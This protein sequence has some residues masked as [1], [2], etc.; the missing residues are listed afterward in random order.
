MGELSYKLGDLQNLRQGNAFIEATSIFNT[1]LMRLILTLIRLNTFQL[2][3]GLP[4]ISN[5][6]FK[7]VSIYQLLVHS[8]H[9]FHK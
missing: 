1:A 5:A 2:A 4:I 3:M 6:R 8:K 7:F 9:K